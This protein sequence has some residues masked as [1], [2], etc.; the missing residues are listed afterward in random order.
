MI[1]GGKKKGDSE[2]G[3]VRAQIKVG[4]VGVVSMSRQGNRVFCSAGFHHGWLV[5][6]A[7]PISLIRLPG[8]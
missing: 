2:K 8:L 3:C 7:V 4:K 5:V 6:R 1:K